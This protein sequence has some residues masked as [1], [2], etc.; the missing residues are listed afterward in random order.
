LTDREER[1]VFSERYRPARMLAMS[2]ETEGQN[3]R[4]GS[5]LRITS[6]LGRRQNTLSS[7][8]L[9][10]GCFTGFVALMLLPAVTAV[11]SRGN[12]GTEPAVLV[13]GTVA[14]FSLLAVVGGW[15]FA[16]RRTLDDS[17]LF[18]ERVIY[19]YGPEYAEV[20]WRHIE[21]YRDG[22]AEWIELVSS[23]RYGRRLLVPT[24]SEKDRVAVL[25]LLDRRG[26]RRLE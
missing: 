21:A 3:A 20:H 9:V 23:A 16:R 1:E 19:F 25:E 2:G 11:M 22:S 15:V 4:S 10:G 13:F 7:C 8:M 6:P 17:I 24:R 5:L 12:G 26:L 18:D 14:F